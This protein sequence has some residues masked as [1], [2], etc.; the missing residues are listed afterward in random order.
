MVFMM[1]IN[2]L[3]DESFQ[4]IVTNEDYIKKIIDDMEFGLGFDEFKS[5]FPF[6]KYTLKHCRDKGFFTNF[7]QIYIYGLYEDIVV[8]L[9][10]NPE[11]LCGYSEHNK[12]VNFV[13]KNAKVGDLVKVKI[14]KAYSWHLLGEE[15]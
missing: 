5:L 9:K 15:L 14:N 10:N 8:Y 11:L 12:L 13:P 3:V 1:L 2:T 4:E 6:Y 7:E